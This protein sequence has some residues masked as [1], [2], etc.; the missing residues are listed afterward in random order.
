M[1]FPIDSPALKVEVQNMTK[2]EE[3]TT[4]PAAQPQTKPANPQPSGGSK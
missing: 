3:Q 1:P 4:Q 2:Q